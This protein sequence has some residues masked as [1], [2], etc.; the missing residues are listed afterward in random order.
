MY[1][2]ITRQGRGD[3]KESS[4]RTFLG[5]RAIKRV[6]RERCNQIGRQD[7]C[8]LHVSKLSR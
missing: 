6:Q 4:E 7:T 1:F 3:G 8:L 2:I 5:A